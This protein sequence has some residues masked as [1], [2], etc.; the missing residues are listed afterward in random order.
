[1]LMS[2][3]HIKITA[4]GNQQSYQMA[5]RQLARNGSLNLRQMQM[6]LDDTKPGLLL[7]HLSNEKELILKKHLL[8]L[9]SL[10]LSV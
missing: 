8:Q 10:P 4:H 3:N 5:K 6:E 7:G 2:L 1:M 9:Q